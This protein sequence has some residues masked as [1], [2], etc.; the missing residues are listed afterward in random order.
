MLVF[1]LVLKVSLFEPQQSV[2][3]HPL[4]EISVP[5]TYGPLPEGRDSWTPF[6]MYHG[7]DFS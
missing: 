6:S 3:V 4:L 1:N 5:G 2:S 7:H